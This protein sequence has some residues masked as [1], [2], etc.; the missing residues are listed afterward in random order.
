MV[1]LE[2]I[3]DFLSG[4]AWKA[5]RFQDS[6]IPIIRIN[7][8]N[9]NDNN[10]VHW[11]EYYDKKYIVNKGDLLLSISGT[12][13]TFKW[14]GPEA[15]L[16]QRILKITSKDSNKVNIDWIFYQLSYET[17]KISDTA[18][19]AII[20]NISINSIKNFEIDLP[21]INIQNKIVSVLDKANS[22]IHKREES[23]EILKQFEI[24]SFL[25]MFSDPVF[26]KKKWKIKPLREVIH[27]IDAGWSPVCEEI[28]RENS[29]QFAVLKQSAVSKRVFDSSQNK[30]LP[31]GTLIKKQILAK[32]ADLLFSRKNSK[33]MV[34]STVYLFEDFDRLLLPDTIFNLRYNSN[35]VSGVYL[36]FLFNDKNFQKKIQ[37]LKNGAAASMPNISQEKL[38]NLDIPLPDI[39]LQN[40]FEKLIISIYEKKIRIKKSLSELNNLIGSISQRAFNG[41]L[42]FNVDLELD[43]L[44]NEIDIQ[45]KQNEIGKI[46]GDIAY[47]QKLIDRLN[48][49]DFKEKEMYDKAKIIAFQLMNESEEKRRV[50]QEYD[51]K[52]KNIKLSLV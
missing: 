18:K 9:S 46:S 36:Y 44:I 23:L 49:Q 31:E 29:N 45:N 38:L 50:T 8:M 30:L 52:T 21:N 26:N 14:N 37:Q 48:T 51:E 33:D 20:K 25:E 41:Q 13:K 3:C 28:P 47:L 6:G 16:N 39:K 40:S 4:N 17:Q 15:L 2:D 11:N 24:D 1:K 42:N 19:E 7:N 12:I 22:L 35:K 34:G 32:K 27:K 43:A 10:F 5:S